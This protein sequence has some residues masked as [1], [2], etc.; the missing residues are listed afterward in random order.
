M[1][2]RKQGEGLLKGR[3]CVPCQWD[4]RLHLP[5]PAAPLGTAPSQPATCD[6]RPE[7]A[8][9]CAVS[10]SLSCLSSHQDPSGTETCVCV[11]GRDTP[12]AAQGPARHT[13]YSAAL[14]PT[15]VVAFLP[16]LLATRPPSSLLVSAVF[17]FRIASDRDSTNSSYLGPSTPPCVAWPC[18]PQSVST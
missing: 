5:H 7:L 14:L 8:L 3:L 16:A 18:T 15:R 12:Q 13:K 4:W 6:K 2:R 17:N 11:C 1:T 9:P 10:T